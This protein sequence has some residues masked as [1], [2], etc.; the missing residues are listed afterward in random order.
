MPGMGTQVAHQSYILMISHNPRISTQP[1]YNCGRNDIAGNSVHRDFQLQTA[2]NYI[3]VHVMQNWSLDDFEQVGTTIDQSSR[4]VS[5]LIDISQIFIYPMI[6]LATMCT[7]CC[8]SH[9]HPDQV[10]SITKQPYQSLL[11]PDNDSNDLVV[12]HVRGS[13]FANVWIINCKLP[14]A[15]SPTFNP[16]QLLI[17]RELL[18]KACFARPAPVLLTKSHVKAEKFVKRS[19]NTTK[20]FQRRC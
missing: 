17:L 6:Q 19:F 20:T 12:G 7:M 1:A 11:P 18:T 13:M 16:R 15:S 5:A 2:I 8:M 3:Y 10:H 4:T 9:G 14:S